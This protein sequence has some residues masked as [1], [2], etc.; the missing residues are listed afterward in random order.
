M[1]KT[2]EAGLYTYPIAVLQE[3]LA[4]HATYKANLTAWRSGRSS[5][6]EGNWKVAFAEEEEEDVNDGAGDR[7]RALADRPR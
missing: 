1:V 2:A 7:C 4:F 5:E 3:A 6:V